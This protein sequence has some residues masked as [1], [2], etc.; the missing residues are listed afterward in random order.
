MATAPEKRP[1]TPT[2]SRWESL[3]NGM[4]LTLDSDELTHCMR[5]GFCLPACPTY[6]ETG[7]EAASPRGRIALMKAVNDGLM[8]PDEAFVDQMNYCLGCRAC[9]SACPADVKFGRLLEQSR[10]AIHEHAP[11]SRRVR[12][13]ENFFFRR[14]FPS[15]GKLRLAGALMAF[16]RKSGLR[17]LFHRS[18]LARVILP[19][20]LRQMDEVLPAASSKGVVERTGTFIPAKGESRGRVGLFRGCIMDVAFAETNCNTAEL[21]S[22]AGYEVVIPETQTCCG[23]LQAHGGDEEQAKEQARANIRAFKDAKVDW[24]ASNAGGCGAQ[25]VEFPYLLRDEPEYAEEARRFGDR[26]RDISQ[27]IASGNPLPLGE[28]D[29]C[30]TYQDSCHLRNG[31][32]VSREPRQLLSAIP[33]T[34]YMELVESDRCCGSAGIYNLTRPETSMSL[35]DGKMEHVKETAAD[36]LVT[37]NPGCLLQMKLGIQ[38]AGLEDRMQAVHLVDLLAESVRKGTRASDEN[39][40]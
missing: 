32:K 12:W 4:K 22:A 29:A 37:T 14:F 21:L 9:E 6:R 38:R 5:C 17:W 24:I 26:I 8:A 30:I 13:M 31:M 1:W 33:G 28:V 19:E 10:A 23:A 15:R 39:E 7:R 35:L 11:R 2:D 34:R 40:K 27:L 18:G 3:E 36:L 16:Y 20:H 25:L